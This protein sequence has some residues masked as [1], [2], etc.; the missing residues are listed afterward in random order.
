MNIINFKHLQ[1]GC[2]PNGNQ[3][4]ICRV[5]RASKKLQSKNTAIGKRIDSRSKTIGNRCTD[6]FH[7]PST[8][9]TGGDNI[10]IDC[11]NGLGDQISDLLKGL[12][13]DTNGIAG[14]SDALKGLKL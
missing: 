13:D 8:T 6:D 5:F 1:K 10:I 4:I 7:A 2:S 14:L 12:T 9:Q 11:F 3:D